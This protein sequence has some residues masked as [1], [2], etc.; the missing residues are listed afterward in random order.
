MSAYMVAHVHITFS[1]PRIL[2]PLVECRKVSVIYQ[3]TIMLNLKSLEAFLRGCSPSWCVKVDEQH[4]IIIY[5]DTFLF[6]NI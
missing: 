1:S 5:S 4:P 3:L 6:N 2:E